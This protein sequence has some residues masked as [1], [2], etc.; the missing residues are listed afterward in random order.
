MK[1]VLRHVLTQFY[2][3]RRWLLCQQWFHATV[4]PAIPRQLRWLLRKLYFLPADLAEFL[5]GDRDEMVPPKSKIFTGAVD[6]FR[7]SGQDLVKRLVGF[8]CL[9]P[10]SRVLD[11]GSGMGRLAV[12]LTAYLDP[13]QGSYEGL[14][15]VPEAID[16]CRKHISSRHPRFTFT[17]A[18]IHNK[19]YLPTGSL[20]ADEYRLPYADDSF[21]L[22]VL[23]SVFTHMLPDEVANYMAEIGRV[24]RSGGHCYATFSLMDDESEKAMDA[25]QSRLR[26]ERHLDSCWVVDHKVPELAV[27]YDS[28]YVQDLYERSGLAAA[29]SVHHG[30]WASRPSLHG[31][32]PGFEQ[33]QVLGRKG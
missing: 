18:D 10:G 20:K 2:E 8:G 7:S 25:G 32:D 4:L 3:L 22:V 6:D 13:E 27:A 33:D 19:E 23:S 1:K 21:D 11:I 24:L 16:W 12:A 15:I 30:S 29:Y 31:R 17:L 28:G 26:F 14:D 5:L 9:T